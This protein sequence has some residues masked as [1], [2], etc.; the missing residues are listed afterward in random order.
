M[1]VCVYR[2]QPV[3]ENVDCTSTHNLKQALGVQQ[4]C[5]LYLFDKDKKVKIITG[6][7]TQIKA[8]TTT[9]KCGN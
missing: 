6:G 9:L 2:M 7:Y 8:L 1:C 5:L 3:G 4:K